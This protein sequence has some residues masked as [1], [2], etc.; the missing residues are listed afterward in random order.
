MKFHEWCNCHSLS[1][2]NCDPGLKIPKPSD[3]YTL[4]FTWI[5]THAN[6]LGFYQFRIALLN[7]LDQS[8]QFVG[9]IFKMVQPGPSKGSNE[10]WL[11]PT[12]KTSPI[13]DLWVND[14]ELKWSFE[15]LNLIG[16]KLLHIGLWRPGS[17]WW[18]SARHQCVLRLLV[19]QMPKQAFI[20]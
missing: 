16:R 12:E 9:T 8:S 15:C 7:R 2:T 13:I 10:R 14:F 17:G 19:I 18:P 4:R 3:W 20:P 5:I 11:F 6:E 1:M